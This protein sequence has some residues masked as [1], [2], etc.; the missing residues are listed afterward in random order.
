MFLEKLVVENIRSIPYAELDFTTDEIEPPM[1]RRW[2][3]LVGE[4][5]TGKST[6]L[7]AAALIL[8][9]SEA[10]PHLIGDCR[11]WVRRGAERG[12][13]TARLR[14]AEWELREVAVDITSSDTV[15]EVLFRNRDDLKPLDDALEHATQNYFVVA[16]GPYRRV[17]DERAAPLATKGAGPAR[18]QCLATLFDKNAVVNPLPAWAMDLDYRRG[19]DGLDIVREALNALMPEVRFDGVDKQKRTLR[20]TTPDGIVSLEELSDGYQNMAA[21]IGDLLY[22]VTESFAH[23]QNPL[24]ARGLL[25]IDEIDAHLHPAW[26]R[27]LRAFLTDRLPNFQILATTHS[28]LTLQQAHENEATILARDE[29]RLVKAT[30]FPGDPSKLRLHQLYDLG[31]RIDSLDSWEIE[32]SKNVYRE[33]SSISEE[34]LTDNQKIELEAAQAKLEVV[35]SERGDDLGNE[36][37]GRYFSTLDRIASSLEAR[38]GGGDGR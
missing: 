36:V 12:R 6:L 23:H 27:R 31:F 1:V 20:F 29:N 10:L 8:A 16:Y 28:A 2:S 9:G 13:I 11:S 25:L 33:L 37:L 7:K 15:R 17:D 38:P 26:Q 3:L 14:T 34:L 21:W 22:Q 4:N 24:R 35:P 19:E 32:Q 18:A 5:G 30:A